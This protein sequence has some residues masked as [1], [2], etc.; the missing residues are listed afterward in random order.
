MLWIRSV[1]VATAFVGYGVAREL[2]PND[3][4]GAELYESGVMMEKIMMRKEVCR[5]MP[6]SKLRTEVADC[7]SD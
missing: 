7:W 3:V 6:I 4:L 5:A 2:V 1:A